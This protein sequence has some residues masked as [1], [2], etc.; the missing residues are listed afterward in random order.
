MEK[1]IIKSY[2]SPCGEMILGAYD[3]K[4]CM[5]DW[6]V[7]KRRKQV[8]HRLCQGIGTTMIEGTAEVIENAIGQFEAYF[9]H[10]LRDFHLPL[11]LIGTDFQKQVWT[12]LQ[13]IP[14]GETVS[15]KDLSHR[16]GNPKAVRAVANANAANALPI[17][18]PCHRVIGADRSLTGFAGGIEAKQFLLNIEQTK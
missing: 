16:I 10:Q 3:G 15:Y 14:F 7:N 12:A 4:L 8:D 17:V 18:I 9:A 2:A 13:E 1:I 5:C 6:S 11:L